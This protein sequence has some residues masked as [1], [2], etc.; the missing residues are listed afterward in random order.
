M[1]AMKNWLIAI[2]SLL[3]K[4]PFM[5]TTTPYDVCNFD[6]IYNPGVY[7]YSLP[8]NVLRSYLSGKAFDH[9]EEYTEEEAER[10]RGDIQDLFQN[11]LDASPLKENVAVITAGAPGAGKAVKLHQDRSNNRNYAYICPDDVCLKNQTRTYIAF[12]VQNK[13]NMCII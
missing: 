3:N 4:D 2:I 1:L 5:N 11:I 12:L 9:P 7:E 6:L 13:S 10:V 8:E